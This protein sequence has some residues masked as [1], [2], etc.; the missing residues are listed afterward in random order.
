MANRRKFTLDEKR[1][2]YAKY[3]GKCAICGQPVK[4][5]KMTV[6]HKV[7]TMCDSSLMKRR[8]QAGKFNEKIT[9]LLPALQRNFP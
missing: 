4:F 6:D 8:P 5:K 3:N 9:A 1:I 7:R 2:V